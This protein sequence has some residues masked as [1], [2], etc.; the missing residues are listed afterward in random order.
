MKRIALT[1]CLLFSV[2]ALTHI[3]VLAQSTTGSIQ[4]TVKDRASAPIPGA[5][6]TAHDAATNITQT[7]TTGEDGVFVVPQLPPGRYTVTVEKAG[8]RKFTKTGV[9]LSAADR[10]SAGTFTLEIGEVTEEITVTADAGALQIQSESGERSA[11]ITGSQIRDL[12][13]NGRDVLDLMKLIPGITSDFDGTVSD[14]GNLSSFNINGAR[15]NQK[16]FTVDGS[17]NVDTGSN[18]GRHVTINP[19]AIAEIKVLTSNYQA[20]FGKAGGGFIQVVT[21]GGTR[22]FSGGARFFHRHE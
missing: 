4:G 11:V 3:Q 13:L 16:E 2:T 17:S 18:G 1:L 9:I 6:V 8:F 12:A 22:R 7:G 21:R 19:D 15:G 14:P 20:E 5:R 10:L